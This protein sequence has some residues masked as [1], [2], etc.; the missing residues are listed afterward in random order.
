MVNYLKG[1]GIEAHYVWVS[2]ETE[3]ACGLPYVVAMLI[4]GE[5]DQCFAMHVD[6]MNELWASALRMAWARGLIQLCEFEKSVCHGYRVPIVRTSEPDYRDIC[7]RCFQFLSHMA[8][9][10]TEADGAIRLKEI[11]YSKL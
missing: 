5:R 11:G 2:R 4:D 8:R 9:V 3:F 10:V 6:K 7:R 1:K